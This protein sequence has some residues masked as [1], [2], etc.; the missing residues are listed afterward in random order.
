MRK[1]QLEIRKTLT[2]SKF[3][4]ESD[5]NGARKVDEL[6][7]WLPV[8]SFARTGFIENF[9]EVDARINQGVKGD[10]HIGGMVVKGGIQVTNSDG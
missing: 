6:N 4:I 3:E 2:H 7:V 10:Q 9:H 1:E 5:I 8:G